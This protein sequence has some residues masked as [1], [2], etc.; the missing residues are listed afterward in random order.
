MEISSRLFELIVD[1]PRRLEFGHCHGDT[2]TQC[3]TVNCGRNAG[4]CTIKQ[5]HIKLTFKFDNGLGYCC[6]RPIQLLSSPCY[7][8]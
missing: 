2:L 3:L 4:R 1:P 7:A 6:L 8:A 5:R